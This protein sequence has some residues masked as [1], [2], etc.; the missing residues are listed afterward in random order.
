MTWASA[1][2]QNWGG[3]AAPGVMDQHLVPHTTAEV[4]KAVKAAAEAGKRVRAI[5]KGHTWTPMFF[6]NDGVRFVHKLTCDFKC[7]ARQ[8]AANRSR[9]SAAASREAHALTTI[10]MSALLTWGALHPDILF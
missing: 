1:L 10:R 6:D 9:A 3:S 5:G 7:K 8:L 2:A 4:A